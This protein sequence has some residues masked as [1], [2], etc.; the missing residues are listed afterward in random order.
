MAFG[1]SAANSSGTVTISTEWDLLKFAGKGSTYSHALLK[2]HVYPNGL[3]IRYYF[4]EIDSPAMPNGEYPTVFF[5]IPTGS[6]AA[7]ASIESIPGGKWRVKFFSFYDI[8]PEVYFFYKTTKG[9]SSDYYGMRLS[10]DDQRIIFDSGWDY[11]DLLSVKEVKS[12]TANAGNYIDI[13]SSISKPAVTFRSSYGHHVKSTYD[14]WFFLLGLQR[15]S[16]R[17]T[18]TEI[19]CQWHSTNHQIG[20]GETYYYDGVSRSVPIIDGSMYD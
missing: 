15:N 16:F 9:Q 14:E 4:T 6:N 11:K 10:G 20:P 18:L 17:Y 1:F 5:H 12:I 7:M 19:A 13:A 8:V 3:T 2:N